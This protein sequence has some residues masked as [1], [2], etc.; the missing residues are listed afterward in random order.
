M[1]HHVTAAQACILQE[2]VAAGLRQTELR[3]SGAP[4]DHLLAQLKSQPAATAAFIGQE[5]CRCGKQLEGLI[6]GL[7]QAHRA[8]TPRCQ[9]C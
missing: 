9:R 4:V 1:P 8:P 6:A 5:S 7:G 3:P 2:L